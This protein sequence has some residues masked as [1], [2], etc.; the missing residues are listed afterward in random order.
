MNDHIPNRWVKAQLFV[1]TVNFETVAKPEAK[2]EKV[3]NEL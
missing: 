3:L 1:P 2:N